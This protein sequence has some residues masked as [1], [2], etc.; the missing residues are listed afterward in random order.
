MK[1]SNGGRVCVLLTLSIVFLSVQ[2]ASAALID[3]LSTPDGMDA[4]GGWT[5]PPGGEGFRLDWEISQ[6]K[7]LS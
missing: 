7:D 6:K 4:G 5:S 3:F 2:S 1:G